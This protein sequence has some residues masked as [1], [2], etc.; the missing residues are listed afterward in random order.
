MRS[1]FVALG[2]VLCALPLLQRQWKGAVVAASMLI[3]VIAPWVIRNTIEF[4]RPVSIISH[5]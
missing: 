2:L 1:E 5:P 4:G 3:V